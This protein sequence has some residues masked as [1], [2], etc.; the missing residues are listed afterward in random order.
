VT[1]REDTFLRTCAMHE[2]PNWGAVEMTLI[3]PSERRR[4]STLYVMQSRVA[5]IAESDQIAFRIVT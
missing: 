3:F 4:C 1:D 2:R 5:L